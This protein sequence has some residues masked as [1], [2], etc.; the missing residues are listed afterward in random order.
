[1]MR[2]VFT[3]ND[4]R[5][6]EQWHYFEAAGGINAPAAWDKSTGSGVV[7][8]V[9]DTGYRPHADLAANILPG[10]DF[11]S[12]TFVANDGNGRDSSALDPGDWINPGECGPGDPAAFEA[13]SWHGTHVSGT[14][15]ALTNNSN[16]VAGIAFNA[17]V[18][19][20]RVLGKCGGFTSD[21]ADA[22][23][24][25]SGG[26][27]AGAGQREPREGGQHLVGRQRRGA[28]R[29]PRARSIPRARA[30]PRSSWPP[31]TATQTRPT[32]RRRTARE[33]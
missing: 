3:P 2:K 12:D 30:A 20:A 11:I 14:I 18:V 22:I 21:I 13:S 6:N 32:S 16:G 31:A 29:R 25:A 7:V 19:P 1:M 8:G 4:T 26:T 10:Y 15:A 33:W 28:T 5:Y 27:V 9:V 17:R 23:I 24:W